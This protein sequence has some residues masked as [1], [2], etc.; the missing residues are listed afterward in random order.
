M[1]RLQLKQIVFSPVFAATCLVS[2]L[3]MVLGL[4][5]SGLDRLYFQDGTISEQFDTTLA[6]SYM[7]AFTS[8]MAV[9]PS[10]WYASDSWEGTTYYSILRSG[11]R[12][13]FWGKI[14]SSMLS[15][16]LVMGIASSLFCI[17]EAFVGY[18]LRFSSWA[19]FY[20][21]PL[22]TFIRDRGWAI[23]EL[24]ILILC[25][26]VTASVCSMISLA[27]SAFTSSRYILVGAPVVSYLGL[28][29]IGYAA[30]WWVSLPYINLDSNPI[31][32][33]CRPFAYQTVSCTLLGLIYWRCS[34]RRLRNG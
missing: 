28:E 29:L 20:Q 31:M 32:M 18:S 7:G 33:L 16:M 6:F 15:G 14:G 17:V 1:L 24:F 30:V 9:L 11:K 4:G 34:E 8:T 22:L 25:R 2:A 5:P 27:L 26:M 13:Y 10:V 21:D 23:L 12:R 19:D 3:V